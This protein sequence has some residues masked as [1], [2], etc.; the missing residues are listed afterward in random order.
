MC[1][2][3]SVIERFHLQCQPFHI[4]NNCLITLHQRDLTNSPPQFPVDENLPFCCVPLFDFHNL[5]DHTLCTA[6]GS[7]LS[8]KQE[9]DQRNYD[10]LDNLEKHK[11]DYQGNQHVLN[12]DCLDPES[13]GHLLQSRSA[14]RELVRVFVANRFTSGRH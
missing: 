2:P 1:S 3:A 8:A 12:H 11:S 13:N 6:D 5:A 14:T 7:P 9:P 4:M 10:M